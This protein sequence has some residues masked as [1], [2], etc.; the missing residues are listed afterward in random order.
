MSFFKKV[1]NGLFNDSKEKKE[2]YSNDEYSPTLIKEAHL[3][4]WEEFSY[5]LALAPE[6]YKITE[7]IF[8]NIEAL[9][10]IEIK[11]KIMPSDDLP[12][13]LVIS[14]DGVEYEVGFYI[15]D[16]YTEEMYQW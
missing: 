10:G 11:E 1:I 5:M 16:F 13:K 3:T 14:Y 8:T 12:G 15:G 7:D 6:N 2:E 4:Y 9:D